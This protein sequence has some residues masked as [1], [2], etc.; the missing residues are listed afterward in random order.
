MYGCH[1]RHRYWQQDKSYSCLCKYIA[2][3]ANGKCRESVAS[4]TCDAGVFAACILLGMPGRQSFR[5][6]RFVI[7][8]LFL[9]V[10]EKEWELELQKHPKSLV[11]FVMGEE[12]K[13]FA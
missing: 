3:D 12:G 11:G 13:S 4:E 8:N 1:H 6:L 9:S 7:H 10:S 5:I 2:V